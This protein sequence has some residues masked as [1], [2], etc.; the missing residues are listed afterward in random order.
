MSGKAAEGTE[1]PF[2]KQRRDMISG[3]SPKKGSK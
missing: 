3:E 2:E 1:G